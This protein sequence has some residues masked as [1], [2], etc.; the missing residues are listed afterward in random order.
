MGFEARL[1]VFGYRYYSHRKG[2][3]IPNSRAREGR[4]FGEFLVWCMTQW[5]GQ[6][7]QIIDTNLD[8]RA[9]VAPTGML[10]ARP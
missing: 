8:G 3:K 4:A 2:Q 7:K 10:G 6:Y 5:G 1:A 9:S